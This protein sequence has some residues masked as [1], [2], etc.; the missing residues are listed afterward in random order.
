MIVAAQSVGEVH[1]HQYA[2]P[3]TPVRW[4]HQVGQIPL[5]A[6]FFQ[7]RS[8][9]QRLEA[10]LSEGGAAVVGSAGGVRAGGVLSGMGGVGKTQLAA[11]YARTAWFEGHVDVLVWITAASAAAIADGFAR[12]GVE[13]LGAELEVAAQAFLAWLEPKP[14]ERVCRWL[15]VLDDVADPEDLRGWWP[16]ESPYG[17]TL[18]TTRRKDAA[19]AGVSRRLIEVGLFN[20]A[21]ALAYLTAAL[22]AHGRREPERELAALARDLGYLPLA[23][24]QAAAYLV[25]AGTACAS[26]RELLADRTRA[27]AD[28]VLVPLPDGQTHTMAAAWA[29]SIDRADTLHPAGLARPMLQLAAFLDPNGIPTTVLTSAPALDH[30][31]TSPSR[32][33][34]S[35]LAEVTSE[36]A[37][38]ALRAL[39]RLS[40]IDHDPA[41]PHQAVR[42][43]QLVQRAVR[44]APAPVCSDCLA[45]TAADALLDAWPDIESDTGL[46]QA[47]RANTEVLTGHAEDALFWP[48]VHKVLG[49]AGDSLGDAGQVAAAHEYFRNLASEATRSLGA[50]H[51]DTLAIRGN[52]AAWQNRGGDPAGAATAYVELLE[53]MGRVLGSDHPHTLATRGNLAASQGEAGDAAGAATAYVELLEDMGRVLGPD[54][55]T[56]LI[57]RSNLARWRGMAGDAAGAATAYAELLKRMVRIFGPD[58]PHTLILRSNLAYMQG[59]AGD[60]AGAVI[61]FAELLEIRVRVLG[62]DHPDTLTTRGN[63]A[64]WRGSAGDAAGAVIAFAELLEA[65]VRVLGPDHPDT[66]TTQHNLAWAR[67]EARDTAGA[68]IAFAE[69][70]ETKG[71]V[72]GPDHPD[73]LATRHNLARLRGE[74]GDAVGAVTAYAE[75]LEH[76]VQVLGPDHPQT[77]TTRHSL[78]RWRGEAGDAVGAVTAYAELL[79]HTVR[80]LGPDHPD[81]LTTRD[82]LDRWRGKTG[83]ARSPLSSN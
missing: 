4:P 40:L 11:D 48:Q 51:P 69:L 12:A 82:H 66:L 5:R 67:G 2:P 73:T 70:L 29:L 53:D 18:V 56:T 6:G 34:S 71:R 49:R 64:R 38:L 76:T 14:Q 62:S 39:H 28:A 42:I 55:P 57:V 25:D 50:D 59:E 32:P 7:A 17:R 83:T 52:L 45:H 79:E 13:V 27:L 58:H 72:L 22:A 80:V 36:H 75:L 60:A 31:T 47:L 15:V 16:P 63:L 61:A 3:R 10:A 30:L 37:V 81:T 41:T 1:Q 24:S 78:A 20:E 65:K 33:G 8:E 54:H 68:A 26:Y 77:L 74:T 44:D 21:E 9:A 23:L 35:D 19:L 46:V 43:H